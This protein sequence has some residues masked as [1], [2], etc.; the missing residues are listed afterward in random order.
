MPL[1]NNTPLVSVVIVTY[2]RKDDAIACIDS[3]LKS[4]YPEFEVIV[5]DNASNDGTALECESR[6]SNKIKLIKSAEN[7]FAGGGRNLGAKSANGEYLLF[8]DSDN[9]VA[10]DM[11]AKLISGIKGN[12]DLRVGLCGPFTYYKCDR[13][14]LCWVNSRISLITSRT[15]FTGTG[16]VDRGQYDKINY[17]KVGHIPNVFMAGADIFNLVGGI[18][19]DYVMHYE[20]SDLAEKIIRLG[21]DVVLFPKAKTWHDI[22]LESIHGHKSFQGYNPAMVYYVV[23]NR[24][25]FMRKNSKGWQ[26]ALFFIIFNNIFLFYSLIVLLANRKLKLAGLA[27]KG[28]RDGLFNVLS[29]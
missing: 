9:I 2:N 8:I 28:Y 26:L 16:E 22:P 29:C 15:V 1:V 7:L 23:R 14:R 6:Y 24:I 20:E 3:V 10:P 18:D 11:I 21:Y 5:V 4:S 12:H 19:K 25:Y 13:N 27:L 17:I